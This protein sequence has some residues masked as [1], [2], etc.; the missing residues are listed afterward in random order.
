MT[1]ISHSSEVVI[2]PEGSTAIP[3]SNEV[4][5]T[6]A[7][8]AAV[9]RSSEV[10]SVLASATAI[11][12][13]SEVVSTLA[14]VAAIPRS[15][16]V[17]VVLAGAAA[18][19][20]SVPHPSASDSVVASCCHAALSAAH[21]SKEAARRT[22]GEAVPCNGVVN[23]SVSFPAFSVIQNVRVEVMQTTPIVIYYLKFLTFWIHTNRVS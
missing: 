4:V 3:R 9:P 20:L 16:E 12:H 21:T 2:A 15:S 5:S 10:I 23:L 19:H 13:S 17:V 7:D 8:A 6:P 18:V 22:R 1:A 11:L 14:G